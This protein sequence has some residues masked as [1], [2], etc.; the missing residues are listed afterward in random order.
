MFVITPTCGPGERAELGD[1]AE[2][3]HRELEDAELGVR[4]DAADRQRHADLGVVAALGGDR[5]AL[6]RA[7]RGEDVLRRGLAHRAGDRDE[8]RAAA[9]ADTPGERRQGGVG[10][11]RGRASAAAP[12]AKACFDEV[13]ARRATATNRSP[14]STRRESVWRPVT[15][16]A[17]GAA[18]QLRRERAPRPRRA[19]AGSRGRLQRAQRFACDLAVVERDDRGPRSPGLARAPCRRSRRRPPARRAR[20][21]GA[22]AARGR[23]R[24]P[25]RRSSRPATSSTIAC[26]SSL[27]GLSEV[28]IATSASSDAIRPICGRLPRSRSPPAPNTQITRPLASSRAA[29]RTFSSAPGLWA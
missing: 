7:D 19:R 27:R 23:A 29:R 21:R 17:Q 11:V 9:L 28:R 14:S 16:V 13:D 3:A 5:S 6:R 10:V 4:L 1:L 25:A 20:S 12:R 22:I 24:L 2:P 26:G 15:S 18:S 8:S